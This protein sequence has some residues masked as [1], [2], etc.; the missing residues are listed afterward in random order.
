VQGQDL[1]DV[2][3]VCPRCG[4]DATER[5]YGPCSACRVELVDAMIGVARES[6]VS[7]FEPTMHVV[8][9]QVATKD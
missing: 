5:F 1:G 2:D 7:K 3:F 4:N 8:P 9:N 6:E